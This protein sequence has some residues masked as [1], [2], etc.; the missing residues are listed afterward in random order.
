[1][2]KVTILPSIP[3]LCLVAYRASPRMARVI[4]TH[5][6]TETEDKDIQTEADRQT[7]TKQRD[8]ETER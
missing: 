4:Q 1:M 3:S 2:Q 7:D 5:T 8:T 6:E